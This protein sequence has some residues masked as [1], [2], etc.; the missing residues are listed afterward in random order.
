MPNEK[1]NK[2]LSEQEATSP[3]NQTNL[4][5][6]DD[7]LHSA[8]HQTEEEEQHRP[9]WMERMA[10]RLEAKE[11]QAKARRLSEEGKAAPDRAFLMMAAV[12]FWAVAGTTLKNGVALCALLVIT[13]I[14]ASY[15]RFILQKKLSLP[16]WLNLPAAI[17]V[18]MMLAAAGCMGLNI[19]APALY[20]SLGIYLFLLA[21]A[22]VLMNAEC[23][24]IPENAGQFWKRTFRFIMD[25]VIIMLISSAVREL[26]GYNTILGA[27]VKMGAVKLDAAGQPFFGL[28]FSGVLAAALRS[29]QTLVGKIVHRRKTA[30]KKAEEASA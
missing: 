29:L 11:L 15:L 25:F 16:N 7:P 6:E 27:S 2:P 30:E 18:S 12:P 9:S 4:N 28:I 8:K 23:Y 24:G 20:D 10:S 19:V 26:L 21:A 17:M 13:L 14:P 3:E 1:Q 5:W 22:P